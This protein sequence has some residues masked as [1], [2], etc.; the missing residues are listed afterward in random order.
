MAQ[1]D[2]NKGA[3]R[4]ALEVGTW[5]STPV[6][7]VMSQ[8]RFTSESLAHQKQVVRSAEVRSDRNRADQLEVGVQAGGDI[9]GEMTYGDWEIFW[10]GALS[11]TIA[12]AIDRQATASVLASSIIGSAT[13]NFVTKFRAGQYVRLTGNSSAIA[14]L[15]TVASTTLT[16]TG[17][18]LV[19]ATGSVTIN[20]RNLRNGTT[21]RSHLI[22]TAFTDLAAVKYFTG[23][24]VSQAQV[25]AQAQ[26]IVSQVFSF[27]GKTGATAS[28]TL[29]TTITT[30]TNNV[31]MTAAVNVGNIQEND[32][33]LATSLQAISFSVNNNLRYQPAVG[34][35]PAIGIGQGG[36]DVT[37]NIN[38]YF[39]DI[40]LY[41]DFINHTAN[42]LSMRFTDT[43]GNAIVVY[44]PKMYYTAGD[45]VITGEDSDVF[46]PLQFAAAVDASV[47]SC[48][49][50]M[51]FLPAS[52]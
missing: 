49:I 9:S 8:V 12:S 19:V 48:Q 5:G 30:A 44:I 21:E 4:I 46:L 37:G 34:S 29:A 16:I 52:P 47:T 39:E 41:Q 51:D 35:K 1:A 2:S 7:T 27:T 17:T 45:P 42:G 18:T 26:Q 31:P 13:T 32:V 6:S 25:N 23:M 50:Q 33:A 22:E 28:A 11:S 20:G 43:A 40:S 38:A 10:Q 15:V 14:R 36:V 24:E 3:V